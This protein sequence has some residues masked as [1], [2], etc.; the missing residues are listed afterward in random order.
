LSG[1]LLG[2]LRLMIYA[3]SQKQTYWVP[4]AVIGC[5]LATPAANGSQHGFCLRPGLVEVPLETKRGP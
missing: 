3:L 1:F 5:A 4:I 2:L